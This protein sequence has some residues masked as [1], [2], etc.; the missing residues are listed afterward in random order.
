MARQRGGTGYALMVL[1]LAACPAHAQRGPQD[2]FVLEPDLGLRTLGPGG[3]ALTSTRDIAVDSSRVYVSDTSADRV[4]VF[5]KQENLLFTFG[6]NGSA[7]NKFSDPW[8]LAVDENRVYIADR[9]N[10]RISVWDKA[11]NWVTNW[12]GPGTNLMQFSVL[13]DV[14]VDGQYL[15]TVERDSHRVQVLTKT[16]AFVRTWGEYGSLSGQFNAPCDVAV[17][18]TS[19]YVVDICN[20]R[21]Q[22]FLKNGSFV[23]S[24]PLPFAYSFNGNADHETSISVD[25]HNVFLGMGQIPAAQSGF[26]VRLIAY[27]KAGSVVWAWTNN[28]S[29]GPLAF[30]SGIAGDNQFL[31]VADRSYNRVY[32]FRRIFRTLGGL[33]NDP[34]PLAE[35]LAVQQRPGT[36]LLDVDYALSDGDDTSLTVY[37][38]AF[39]DPGTN[40][41]TL[42]HFFPM[43]SFAEGTQTNIGPGI[44]TSG[45][46]RLT[47][48]LDADG[49]AASLGDYGRLRVAILAKDARDLLDLHFL[50]IPAVGTN[51]AVTI[52]RT[53][54]LDADLL[55]VWYWWLAAGDTNLTLSTGTVMAASGPYA[56]TPLAQ[57]AATTA[58]GRDYLFAHLNLRSATEAEVRHARGGFSGGAITNTPRR[59]PPPLGYRV[60]EFNFVI[61]PTNGWFVVPLP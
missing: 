31:Y 24:W 6:S 17:D 27:D 39:L 28:P 49:A 1:M 18:D 33:T 5:D 43:R 12:G 23:R 36:R 52:N 9:G 45:V 40:A 61:W 47:W 22:V 58:T 37:A 42:A 10:N 54:L 14:A 26:Y 41:P 13:N 15:Y 60:N 30:P 7:S 25:R 8:G 44:G 57:G 46:R 3:A 50:T 20:S 29:V 55:P 4:L 11:G 59:E 19:V 51:P 48:D 53:P 56:G 21:I 38:G 16:G 32:N 34:I 35:V 2:N